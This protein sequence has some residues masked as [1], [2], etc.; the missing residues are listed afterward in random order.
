MSSI[1]GTANVGGLGPRHFWALGL[2]TVLCIWGGL[3][4]D[5]LYLSALP[6]LV[7]G[8]ALTVFDFRQVYFLMLASLPLSTEIEL[9][10]G[11]GTDLPDEALIVGLFLISIPWGLSRLGQFRRSFVLHPITLMLFV[12]LAWVYLCAFRSEN[13]LVS[14][15]WVLAKT[16]Y[17]VVFYFLTAYLLKSTK[18]WLKFFGYVFVPLFFTVL[19]I[20]ARHAAKGFAFAEINFVLKPFY[21]NHVNYSGILALFI[22]VLWY[23]SQLFPRGSWKRFFLNLS[24]PIMLLALYFT[25][26]RAAYLSVL[27]A[28]GAA[29]VVYFKLMR[30]ILIAAAG[31]LIVGSIYLVDNNR[32][33]DYA[34]DFNRTI[35]HDNFGNLLEA[36]YKLEDISTM[37]RVY[38]WVAAMEMSKEHPWMGYGP[39]NFTGFYQSYAVKSF[40]TYVS[41]NPEGS[42]V[43][44]YYLMTLVEQGYPG[45]IIFILLSFVVLLVG[46]R[47]YHQCCDPERKLVIMAM[48][49]C[50]VVID[51]FLLINDMVETD[52]MGS[53]FF[54]AMAVLAVEDLDNKGKKERNKLQ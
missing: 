24:L 39:G 28:A 45:L 46:E 40:E 27:I 49:L 44:C 47:A 26:T 17:V 19:V 2:I 36:T 42:G 32:Y 48:L 43:H 4:L 8:I 53:F 7:L 31:L 35:S 14:V 1:E 16:W 10:G 12:H 51:A 25:Y 18:D 41:D 30:P 15:K 3:A 22:P 52:K 20:M 34:P 38:R 29:W 33:L 21:R 11:F 54:I 13:L 9:P 5:A 37:E 6:L 50:T 23:A